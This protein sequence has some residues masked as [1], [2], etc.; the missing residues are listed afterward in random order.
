MLLSSGRRSQLKRLLE[1]SRLSIDS[2]SVHPYFPENFLVVFNSHSCKDQVLLA[3]PIRTSRVTLLVRHW[4]RIS[5]AVSQPL[6]FRVK[7]S[8]EGLPLHAWSL[9]AASAILSPSCWIE[10][11][12]ESSTS[13]ADLSAFR[14]V[15]WSLNPNFIPKEKFVVLADPE[16]L[17]DGSIL[18]PGR[19]VF[20]KPTGS[21]E[22]KEALGYNV[23]IHIHT[24]E[25][26]TSS[27]ERPMAFAPSSDDSGFG[28]LPRDDS[29]SPG[30]RRFSFRTKPGAVD[31]SGQSARGR[32]EAIQGRSS[33]ASSWK[34]PPLS[35]VGSREVRNSMPLG[36]VLREKEVVVRSTPCLLRQDAPKPARLP[37]G[38]LPF[39]EPKLGMR[40]PAKLTHALNATA[41]PFSPVRNLG[42]A[43]AP[44]A[45]TAEAASP[46]GL[47]EPA[48][49]VIDVVSR[50]CSPHPPVAPSGEVAAATVVARPCSHHPLTT[51]TGE[52]AGGPSW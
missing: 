35:I 19:Q 27:A 26:F 45:P 43:S 2:F 34:L 48:V 9:A 38:R 51:T 10:A 30:S 7:L 49:P 36:R 47:A 3:S 39:S 6:L 18:D 20:E 13:R 4:S 16:A 8:L 46:D 21:R 52:I 5:Q 50:P 33:L 42:S 32:E 40:E 22:F 29:D 31:G 41:L 44:P 14:L 24:V 15:A 25:D 17:P 1:F 28:G 12:D 23:I 37:L 11:F